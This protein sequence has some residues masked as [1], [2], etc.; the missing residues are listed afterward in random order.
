MMKTRV[1]V[2]D[3]S[4]TVR[5]LVSE[6]L[7]ATPDFEVSASAPNG[8]I[9]LAKVERSKPDIITL[10]VE[11][12]EMDGLET[13]RELRLRAP[14]VPVLMFS[15]VTGRGAVATLEALTMGAAD[16]V[17]KPSIPNNGT[18]A[19]DAVAAE[20]LPKLRALAPKVK[21]RTPSTMRAPDGGNSARALPFP[22]VAA[23]PRLS[24]PPMASILGLASD[25]EILAIGASTGGPAAVQSLL[26]S[27]PGSLT[28]PIVVA[29]HMPPVFTRLFAERLAATTPFAVMEA[30]HGA[31]LL[32]GRCYVAP[33]DYHMTVTR[34]AGR[35][36]VSINQD[37]PE[38]SCRPAVDPLFRSVAETFGRHALAVV[39]TGMGYDGMRGASLVR[40]AGGRVLAQDEAT[41]VVWG[42]PGAVARAGVAEAVLP[43][44]EI[45]PAVTRIVDGE[46][47]KGR[48]Q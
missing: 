30:Q 8:R 18:G 13:L 35:A 43:L 19:R 2:V 1:M 3:D 41:S 45:G 48:V 29:Q 7:E 24:V 9:A 15:N 11:M 32:P 38:H 42:M 40:E 5:R 14:S 39:L 12:P 34:Q 26:A 28:V 6:V 17:Q 31:P 36:H 27:L 20:L 21:V 25:I 22:S 10:D 47:A 37:P 16:Y 33:G 46:R 44:G 4:A 23:P